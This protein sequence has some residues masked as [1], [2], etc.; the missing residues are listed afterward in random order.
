MTPSEPVTTVVT[1]T[2]TV[3]AALA[4]ISLSLFSGVMPVPAGAST[5]SGGLPAPPVPP[6]PSTA[7]PSTAVE[8]S[9][10]L[11]AVVRVDGELEIISGEVDGLADTV[12]FATEAAS[13]G[14]LLALEPDGTASIDSDP[15]RSRQWVLDGFPFEAVNADHDGSGV[16][17]AVVDTAV[18]AGHEDLVGALV[19]GWDFVEDRAFDVSAPDRAT[20]GADHGSHVAGI[21]AARPDN[22]VGIRG[23]APG[24]KVQPIRVLPDSGSGSVA[25]V[26]RGILWAVDHGADVI[27]V[28]LGT[29]ADSTSL[30]LAIGE[31]ESRGVVVVASA[32]NN[33][34]GDNRTWFPAAYPTVLSVG[35]TD[36]GGEHWFRSTVG[37]FIDISGPGVGVLSLGGS[38]TGTYRTFSGTSMAT[39]YV[40]ATLALMREAAPAASVADI[41]STLT[42]TATDLGDPGRDPVY[43]YGLIDPAAAVGA[44]DTAAPSPPTTV[45]VVTSADGTVA[46]TWQ[47]SPSF[48]VREY[49]ITRDGVPVAAVAAPD[50]PGPVAV[51]VSTLPF[52]DPDTPAQYGVRAVDFTDNRS[53]VALPEA[54]P[55]GLTVSPGAHEVVVAWD[56]VAGAVGY[57]VETDSA[58][59]DQVAASPFVVERSPAGS[60]VTVRVAALLAPGVLGSFTDQAS[61]AVG[62]L[63]P[64]APTGLG[65]DPVPGGVVLHWDD[66]VGSDVPVDEVRIAIDGGAEVSLDGSTRTYEW[67][68]LSPESTHEFTVRFVG[69][70]GPGG[71]A[72]IVADA[73]ADPRLPLEGVDSQALSG[74]YWI[75][76]DAG[77]VV[78][79]G[80]VENLGGVAGRAVAGAPTA[81]GAGYWIVDGDGRVSAFGDARHFGDASNLALKGPIVAMAPTRTGRGYWLLG[82]DGGVFSFGDAVFHGSTGG[83]VLD[84]PVVDMA[85]TP[86]GNGYWLVARDG[87]VFSFGDAVFHGSTGGLVLDEPVVSFAVGPSGYWLVASDGGVFAFD[88]PF[89]GSIRGLLP[90]TPAADLPEVLRVRGRADGS[91]YLVL[92]DRGEVF[93]FGAATA[94]GDVSG[95]LT[96]GERAVDL[97]YIG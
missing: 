71:V 11:V 39:P 35:A 61:A 77:R 67:G 44:Y 21:L 40:A 60:E 80:G 30:R 26:A 48:D 23:A 53:A 62:E 51:A 68:G 73:G 74:S 15:L 64:G 56:P 17:V 85:V 10:E 20:S 84:A 93:S 43:G 38:T 14:E 28:S 45:S 42:S 25:D 96:D 27:N 1:L 12:R 76:T 83:L 22:G 90:D 24:V 65:A 78:P 29:I 31:A 70:D 32:G 63:L 18:A 94:L 47:P 2:L 5:V 81:S 88:V 95:S 55:G 46:F 41:R 58:T 75:L 69:G 92:G 54:R 4:A 72:G 91:G 52:L 19:D 89:H 7:G 86:S 87:G 33:G 8:S 57:V 97:L 59:R 79:V 9:P 66:P 36:S 82:S 34:A 49:E 37:S 3:R 13:E 50:S 6:A 16:I